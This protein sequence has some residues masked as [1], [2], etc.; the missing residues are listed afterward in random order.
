MES[1]FRTALLG[2]LRG[3][4]S[5]AAS[6]NLIGEEAP[7]NTPAPTL[8]IAASASN[9]WSNKSVTGRDIRLALEL[10]TRGDLPDESTSLAN[11][12]EH[13]IATLPAAQDGLRVVVT[14]FLRSRAQRRAKNLR[15]V[16]IEYRFL[17]LAT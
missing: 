15:A 10:V 12:I 3:D 1:T 2:W 7:A 4:A 14:Q 8:T 13:R 6:L 5:L 17:V 11:T 9:D 16:L